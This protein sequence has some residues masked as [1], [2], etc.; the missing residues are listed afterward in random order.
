MGKMPTPTAI[1]DAKGTF[2]K[3]P[4]YKRPNEP[5]VTAPLGSPP[6]HLTAEQKKAWKEIAKQIPPGVAK[7]AD[8]L[9][10][11]MMS[12]LLCK[13]RT[14][15]AKA[16]ETAQLINLLARFGMTPA[17]R[18]KVSAGEAPKQS[19]IAAFLKKKTETTVQ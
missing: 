11:E 17:D 19:K 14:G 5:I 18:T 9:S 3:H 2:I 8:R 1:L 7:Q 12:V 10:L 16:A 6:A 15:N 13:F 4:E